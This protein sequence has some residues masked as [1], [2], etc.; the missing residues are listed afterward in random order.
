MLVNNVHLKVKQRFTNVIKSNKFK[1]SNQL[2][3][4]FFFQSIDI[5]LVTIN[6]TF[7]MLSQSILIKPKLRTKL[8]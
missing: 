1:K 4:I 5:S 2:R 7:I 6:I 3:K 8:S